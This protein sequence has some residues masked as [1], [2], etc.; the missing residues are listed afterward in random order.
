[1]VAVMIHPACTCERGRRGGQ[2]WGGCGR[3]GAIANPRTQEGATIS[4]QDAPRP[5]MRL[6]HGT[7]WSTPW[8]RT[9]RSSFWQPATRS[10]LPRRTHSPAY[11]LPRRCARG[12]LDSRVQITF[13][14]RTRFVT[15]PAEK[16]A[17]TTHRRATHRLL[18]SLT[19]V[20]SHARFVIEVIE[21]VGA[22][23]F[24]SMSTRAVATSRSERA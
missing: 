11:A 22:D 10:T 18:R 2:G 16:K 14:R 19:C 6:Q 17:N 9:R 23:V 20:R 1:L 24:N 7:R 3:A 4:L 12:S 13:Y 15:G 5:L 21:Y 8:P